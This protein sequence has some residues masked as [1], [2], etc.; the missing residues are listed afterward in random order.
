MIDSLA[1]MYWE[2][3]VEDIMELI[4]AC[5]FSANSVFMIYIVCVWLLRQCLAHPDSPWQNK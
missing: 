1:Y 4:N 2:Y 3:T 5:Q